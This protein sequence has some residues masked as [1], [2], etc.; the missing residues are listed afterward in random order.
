[1]VASVLNIICT[2]IIAYMLTINIVQVKINIT[3]H[4]LP[5]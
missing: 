4:I 5:N 2:N 1:M 3:Q